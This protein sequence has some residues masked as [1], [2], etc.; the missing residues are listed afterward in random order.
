MIFCQFLK[1][2]TAKIA[3]GWNLQIEDLVSREQEA[4]K[5][6]TNMAGSIE[7]QCGE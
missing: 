5:H 7:C 3:P 2:P 6:I 1:I 4:S